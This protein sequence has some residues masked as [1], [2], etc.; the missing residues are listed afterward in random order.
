M[1]SSEIGG[2]ECRCLVDRLNSDFR[3]VAL[4]LRV[5][6]K[7]IVVVIAGRHTEEDADCVIHAL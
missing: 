3:R 6:P 4:E 1:P 7:V 2:G 5:F